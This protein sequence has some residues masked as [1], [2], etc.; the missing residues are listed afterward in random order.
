MHPDKQPD[1]ANRTVASE[2]FLKLQE[3]YEV[4]PFR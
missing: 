4:T 1:D 3:A 2:A